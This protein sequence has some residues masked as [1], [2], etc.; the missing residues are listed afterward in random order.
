MRSDNL[1]KKPA[2]EFLFDFRY[3][4][5]NY[6]MP[7]SKHIQEHE[8]GIFEPQRHLQKAAYEPRPP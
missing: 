1:G 3:L 4:L 2:A 7:C 6:K 8:S 5:T